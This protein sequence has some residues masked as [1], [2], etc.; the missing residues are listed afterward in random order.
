MNKLSANGYKGIKFLTSLIEIKHMIIYSP[1]LAS[2]HRASPLAAAQYMRSVIGPR[3]SRRQI[4]ALPR[5][6]LSGAGGDAEAALASWLAASPVIDGQLA[7][8]CRLGFQGV[9]S[10]GAV[11]TRAGP[12]TRRA[13][14]WTVGAGSQLVSSELKKPVYV[15]LHHSFFR[16]V[17]FFFLLACARRKLTV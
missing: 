1:S 6:I 8:A 7:G 12:E 3:D 10:A 16:G 9:V 15:Y 5:P 4:G 14:P 17:I 11:R 2:L 13:P